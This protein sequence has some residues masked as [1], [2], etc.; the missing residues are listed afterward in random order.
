MTPTA[1]TLLL[2]LSLLSPALYADVRVEVPDLPAELQD[3]VHNALPLVREEGSLSAARV[4]YLHSRADDEI[5]RVLSAFSYFNAE[6]ES[7]LSRD[8]EDWVATYRVQ[9]GPRTVIHD[10]TLDVLGEASTQARFRQWMADPAL[11]VGTPL[12]QPAYESLKSDLLERAAS[13]GF[14]EARFTQ[15]KIA[16]DPENN[17]AH[18]T[19]IFDSGPQYR[20]GVFRY[21]PAPV[22]QSLL[23][24]Y[25]TFKPGDPVSTEALLTMQRGLIDSD[26]FSLVEVQP[27]WEEADAQ[28]Q[29]PIDV[30]LEPNKR[31]AYRLGAGY[32]T[33]TGGRLSARQNRRW[34]NSLGHRMD[35]VLR[36]SEVTNTLSSRYEIPGPDPMTDLYIV[37]ALYEQEQTDTTD[38]EKWVLGLQEQKIRNGHR[39]TYGL[40]LEEESFTF[41]RD[42]QTTRLLVPEFGWQYVNA[43]NRLYPNRGYRLDFSLS[44][45]SETLLSDT[46]FVQAEAGVKAVQS[47]GERWRLL[48]RADVGATAVTDFSVLPSSRRFFAG[49]DNSVR[50]YGYKRLAPKDND[51]DVRGGRYMI[52]G[53]VE[54]DYLVKENWRAALFWDTGNAFDSID[55][56]LVSGVGVGARWQS[57]V[58]PVRID[59]AKPLDD[60]GIRLHF[61]LGPDL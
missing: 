13:A 45:G 32:G 50:G 23:E 58:G 3:P 42:T 28:Q 35:T 37:R 18:I 49:G 44:G 8:G 55:T 26:Y 39:F 52:T 27:R 15:S 34:V 11:R 56:P 48:G 61:T 7:L 60:D 25:E 51:G 47:F 14:Y 22:T 38:T 53:S 21:S 59:L 40:S 29:V 2:S 41:G 12:D 20:V 10:T 43:D 24:R 46:D 16:V 6:I 5:R 1:R 30:S 9:L 17:Q 54:V 19:L 33:D 36:L 57:P 31:T 4:R